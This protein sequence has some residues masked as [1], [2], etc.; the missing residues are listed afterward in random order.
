MEG[1]NKKYIIYAVIGIVLVVGCILLVSKLSNKTDDGNENVPEVTNKYDGLDFSLKDS[2]KLDNQ[3]AEVYI[4][5]GKIFFTGDT[6]TVYKDTEVVIEGKNV[7]SV[8]MTYSCG[9]LSS[10]VYLTE[11]NKLYQRE[12]HQL[13]PEDAANDTLIASDAVGFALV[14][15]D[16]PNDTCGGQYVVYKDTAGNIKEK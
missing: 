3:D 9:G 13:G 10:I 11:D 8:A 6:G 4:K 7:V 1:K 2:Y 15:I 12:F 16:D 5:D 14:K